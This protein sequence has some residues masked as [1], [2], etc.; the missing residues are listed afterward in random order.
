MYRRSWV[1]FPSGTQIFSL[2]HAPDKLNITIFLRARFFGNHSGT[3]ILGIA[4]CR[5]LSEIVV[6][7][8]AITK[9]MTK[10]KVLPRA[11]YFLFKFS[12]QDCGR[13]PRWVFQS[14]FGRTEFFFFH[15][16]IILIIPIL[17]I[18]VPEET[19]KTP[20]SLLLFLQVEM[21][22]LAFLT[23]FLFAIPCARARC[24][25]TASY[26]FPYCL[27]CLLSSHVDFLDK[28]ACIK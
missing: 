25:P 15:I 14:I 4:F 3:R 10:I 7:H 20:H 9:W 23:M 27:F 26:I 13:N 21:H 18:L 2:S 16:Q 6:N 11:A 24:K 12:H 28:S 5:V 1:R 17:L 22:L 8:L 19:K